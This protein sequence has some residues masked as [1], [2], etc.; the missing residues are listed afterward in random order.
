MA[1]ET[2]EG[3]NDVN[4]GTVTQ[5]GGQAPQDDKTSEGNQSGAEP[6]N[7]TDKPTDAES[8]ATDTLL[9]GG[10][11]DGEG[12]AKTDGAP[13]SYEPFDVE[14]KQFTADQVEGFTSV[15]KELGLSQENAQKVLSAVVPTA[16][17]YLMDDLA[18]TSK[19]WAEETRNDPDLGGANFNQNI[20]LAA[21]AYKEYCS[22]KL[23]EI[24]TNSGLGN[25]PEVVRLFCRLGREM[26]QDTGV[27]GS[28][29][30]SSPERRRRYPN[31]NM[32]AD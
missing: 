18:A 23:K 10:E 14:G 31:S 2:N 28:A 16:R 7:P 13:E 32:V 8:G 22:P 4:D 20:G 21:A 12:E 15:A 24:L 27:S 6:Q 1:D 5:Q 19:K 29:S 9:E 30:A 17:K 26:R 25:H 3:Q 11:K